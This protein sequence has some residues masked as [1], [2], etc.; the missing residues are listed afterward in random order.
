[1]PTIRLLSN[2]RTVRAGCIDRLRTMQIHVRYV[3]RVKINEKHENRAGMGGGAVA[4]VERTLDQL[5]GYHEHII[6]ALRM[7]ANQ[8]ETSGTTST[9]GNPM[10]DEALTEPLTEMLTEPLQDCYPTDSYRKDIIKHIDNQTDEEYEEHMPT[11]GI[12]RIRT[13]EDLIKQLERHSK[14]KSPNGSECL[15]ISENE[16]PYRKDSSVCSE[17]SQG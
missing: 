1:M 9:G 2:A 16:G 6:E 5:N 14:D 12:I 13:L 17:S 7:A 3:Q 15:G 10:D 11:C 4:N 8:R